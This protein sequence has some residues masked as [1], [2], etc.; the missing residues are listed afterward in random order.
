MLSAEL[1]K[2]ID[3]RARQREG[4]FAPQAAAAPGGKGSA[5]DEDIYG[6][7]VKAVAGTDKAKVLT[8]DEQI[9]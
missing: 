5:E 1:K 8:I 7:S 3:E 9:A 2:K 4:G 6:S